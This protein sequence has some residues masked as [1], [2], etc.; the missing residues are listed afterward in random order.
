MAFPQGIDFRATSGFVTDTGSNYAEL[1]QGNPSGNYP[2]VTPQGNTVGFVSSITDHRDRNAGDDPR[3]AGTSF[4]NGGA[5]TYRIDLPAAG[6]YDIFAGLGDG[7]YA[8]TVNLTV[9]DNATT[10]YTL[11]NT[12]TGAGNSFADISGAVSTAANWPTTGGETAGNKITKTFASTIALF[13]TTGGAVCHLFIQASGAPAGRTIAAAATIA[14]VTS[15]AALTVLDRIASAR[16]I[17]AVTSS[18]AF[19][20]AS[21]L[22]AAATIAPLTAAA[23]LK[24]AVKLAAAAAIG[25]FASAAA[26]SNGS[27]VKTITDWLVTQSGRRGRR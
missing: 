5:W 19:K 11:G 14:A 7:S 10:L 21:H 9:L 25:A 12:S 17:A 23:A 18:A 2:T 6:A 15:S 20:V 13:Q 24:V 16:T 1:T 4:P 22:S 27:G 8:A 3:I 26:F